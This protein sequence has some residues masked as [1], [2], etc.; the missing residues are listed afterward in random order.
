MI[1]FRSSECESNAVQPYEIQSQSV[2]SLHWFIYFKLSDILIARPDKWR[3]FFYIKFSSS[4]LNEVGRQCKKI[5]VNY[6]LYHVFFDF[7]IN[8][9]IFISS[10]IKLWRSIVIAPLMI[11]AA[12]FC[13]Q[14]GGG[15]DLTDTK[16]ILSVHV[17]YFYSWGLLSSVKIYCQFSWDDVTDNLEKY[18][19]ILFKMS[20]VALTTK[21]DL[22]E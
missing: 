15:G 9:I 1:T 10:S 5:C 17:S 2:N 11:A 20:F 4:D 19:H 22:C 8:P 21:S 13:T 6:N 7:I 18:S 12:F 14:T 3:P 16:K